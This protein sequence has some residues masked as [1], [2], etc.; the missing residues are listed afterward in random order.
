ME[1]YKDFRPTQFDSHIELEDRE[2]W[3]VLNV[4]Q[5]RDSDCLSVSN[6]ETA[7]KILGEKIPGNKEYCEHVEV[8]RFGH[9]GPGWFEIILVHPSL[10]EIGEEI[11]NRLEDY[12][13]LD[14]DDFAERE[15]EAESEA[16]EL[17]GRREMAELLQKEFGLSE[18]TVDWF[19][20]NDRMFSLYRDS[21]DIGTE[22]TSEGPRFDTRWITRLRSVSDTSARS[23]LTREA[24]ANWIRTQ[25]KYERKESEKSAG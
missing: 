22:H 17:W 3:Y 18:S 4:G 12:P 14:E 13:I 19:E 5:T 1:Q 24:L 11:E 21:S 16:W 23:S 8:H 20:Q 10:K 7:Q 25:R 9:W 6:F 15:L 2:D